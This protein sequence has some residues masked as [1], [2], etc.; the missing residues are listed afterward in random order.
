[1]EQLTS[2]RELDLKSNKL[3][4][5]NESLVAIPEAAR[6][7][8]KEM[9]KRG[10]KILG[11]SKNLESPTDGER[12]ARLRNAFE[13]SPDV[14]FATLASALEFASPTELV[15]WLVTTG[16]PGLRADFG[17]QVIHLKDPDALAAKDNIVKS[18][19][20]LGPKPAV[21]PAATPLDKSLLWDLN[22]LQ[23]DWAMGPAK[24]T[25]M[26]G[27]LLQKAGKMGA[28][29]TVISSIETFISEIG[30]S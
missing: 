29:R 24:K 10:V 9:K 19:A 17:A 22:R 3:A 1:M 5:G 27:E 15:K 7:A 14:P 21:D 12:L 16:A 6:R 4:S 30:N 18:H 28:S 26:A 11:F 23:E 2:L 8:L 25:R 13:L 20:K